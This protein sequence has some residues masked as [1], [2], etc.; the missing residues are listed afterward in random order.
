MVEFDKQ[1]PI[2]GFAQ[3]KGYSAASHRSILLE[4]SPCAMH[5]LS[6][7]AAKRHGQQWPAIAV[8]AVIETIIP[9]SKATETCE[10]KVK[11]TSKKKTQ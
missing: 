1:F 7:G 11:G 4:T 9:S 10:A 5:R 6:Y 2:Y 8:V 3:H